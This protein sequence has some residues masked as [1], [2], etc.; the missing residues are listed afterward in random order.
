LIT[1]Q[2]E[3]RTRVIRQQ[4]EDLLQRKRADIEEAIETGKGEHKSE[5]D[6]A[7][8]VEDIG[9]KYTL[10]QAETSRS[11]ADNLESKHSQGQLDLR[12]QVR[13][14]SVEPLYMK[15]RDYSLCKLGASITRYNYMCKCMCNFG[16]SS[17][18]L[19]WLTTDQSM[20]NP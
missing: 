2:Y 5:K 1:A 15:H 16:F 19:W 4:L 18:S 10:L 20:T 7:D 6:I 11:A 9:K 14:N 3:E 12:Q 13:Q 8:M 17:L